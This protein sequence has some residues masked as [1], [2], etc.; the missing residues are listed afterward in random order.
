MLPN[1]YVHLSASAR[2]KCNDAISKQFIESD[3]WKRAVVVSCV[4]REGTQIPDDFPLR[5]ARLPVDRLLVLA[6][7]FDFGRDEVF[8][9]LEP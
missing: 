5:L 3:S 8:L 7:R 6:L 9:P 1:T 4:E 2:H